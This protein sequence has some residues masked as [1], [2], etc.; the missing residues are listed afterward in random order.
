MREKLQLPR[1]GH[2]YSRTSGCLRRK[3]ANASAAQT[4]LSGTW[5]SRFEFNPALAVPRQAHRKAGPGET[6]LR[7]SNKPRPVCNRSDMP[8]SIWSFIVR[9]SMEPFE[10][11]KANDDRRQSISASRSP[12]QERCAIRPSVS[13][14][15]VAPFG[16][17]RDMPHRICPLKGLSRMKGNFHVRF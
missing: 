12:R 14:A 7:G 1:A 9:N 8:T 16:V 5:K 15:K 10:L 13:I 3:R 2:S 6:A 11:R 4:R 17:G